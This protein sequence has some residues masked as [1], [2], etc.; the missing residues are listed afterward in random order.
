[1]DDIAASEIMYS[2]TPAATPPAQRSA[3]DIAASRL[4]GESP[5]KETPAKP[6]ADPAARLF[7]GPDTQPVES[8]TREPRTEAE[9]AT[10]LF[11]KPESPEVN[12]DIPADILAERQAD[13]DRA[14]FSPKETFREVLP[15]TM[16]D[17]DPAAENIPEHVRVAVVSEYR[18]MAADLGM[19]MADV[20]TLR[21]LSGVFVDTPSEDQVIAWREEAVDHL[22]R[23]YGNQATQALRDAQAFIALDPRRVKMLELN[24]RGDHPKVIELFARLGRKARLAGKLK[25]RTGKRPAA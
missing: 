1:M 9:Q 20:K 22:N 24:N 8:E 21:D 19:D 23:T 5:A 3:D 7:G 2:S 6:I 4:Y 25:A 16:L 11:G 12:L 13:K 15:D 10:A 18:E 17:E 14:L